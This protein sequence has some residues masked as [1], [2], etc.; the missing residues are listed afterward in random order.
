[1]LRTATIA[2]PVQ[3]WCDL[4]TQCVCLGGTPSRSRSPVV[5]VAFESTA[6]SS[7]VDVP[8]CDIVDCRVFSV[9]TAV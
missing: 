7:Y 2:D 3:Q 1:M 6:A 5:M 9:F 4:T 8:R